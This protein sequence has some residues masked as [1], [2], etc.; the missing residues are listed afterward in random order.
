M[1]IG[2]DI[3]N[4]IT[5]VQEQLN[6]A[7]FKYAIKLG[8]NIDNTGNSFE[9]IKNN[10]D[11]YKKKF[12]FSY[13][14]LKYFLKNIQEEITNKAKPRDNAVETINRLKKEGHKIIII[15]ARDSEFHDNPYLLSKNWLDKNNIKYDK[16]IVNA[17]EK[18]P[19]CKKENIDLF[20][21]DQL[22]N[23]IEVT[24]E[25]I[26]TI[27]ISDDKDNFENIEI[28][29]NWKQIYEYVQKNK[30]IKIVKYND[31]YKDEICTFINDCM[32]VFINRPY[33]NRPDVSNINDYYIKCKGNFWIAIDVNSRK[34]VGSIALE[35]RELY[36]ILKRF[37]VDSNYQRLGIGKRLYEIF[38]NYA[39]NETDINKIYLACANVLKN[40]H[41]FY[42]KNGFIQINNLDINMNYA[43]DDDFFIKNIKIVG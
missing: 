36:G 28:V 24:K 10:G 16:L 14:E 3:D 4:T 40:A 8:K 41:N 43:E 32:H 22:N 17:R 13:N 30:I 6:N 27:R 12:K 18:A 26:Q 9:D 31:I 34:I 15:T 19:I 11:M 42:I 39:I 20:I 1:N 33:K 2:I 29:D 21:D 7:A 38:E 23:C 37:Y 25:G 35:N 5:E